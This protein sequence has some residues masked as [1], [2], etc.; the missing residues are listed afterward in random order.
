MAVPHDGLSDHSAVREVRSPAEEALKWQVTFSARDVVVG[1]VR[2]ACLN[3]SPIKRSDLLVRFVGT[4]DLRQTT[5]AARN[6]KKLG[7]DPC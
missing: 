1:I 4:V 6:L 7:D 2:G 5:L 3:W